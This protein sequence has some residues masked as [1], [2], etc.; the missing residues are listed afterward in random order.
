[1]SFEDRHNEKITQ[2]LTDKSIAYKFA[3]QCANSLIGTCGMP[4]YIESGTEFDR[5]VAR[6]QYR[7]KSSQHV[8]KVVEA[9]KRYGLLSHFVT[10]KE[11][12]VYITI[13]PTKSVLVN[14]TENYFEQLEARI[15]NLEQ[16]LKLYDSINNKANENNKQEQQAHNERTA[17]IDFI[18][19][20]PQQCENKESAAEKRTTSPES[21]DLSINDH[22][23]LVFDV[24][25][26]EI[27]EIENKDIP[28]TVVKQNIEDENVKHLI[29]PV[30]IK[31]VNETCENNNNADKISND[32]KS[33]EDSLSKSAKRRMKKKLRDRMTYTTEAYFAISK[34]FNSRE[35][36]FGNPNLFKWDRQPL[37]DSFSL[38]TDRDNFVC[39]VKKY[40][41]QFIRIFDDK[42]SV[43]SKIV[44]KPIDSNHMLKLPTNELKIGY[45]YDVAFGHA[46]L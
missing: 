17:Q 14:R 41:A 23:E 40:P 21:E 24:V 33:E 31:D 43:N 20:S 36:A 12:R 34:W 15:E 27:T 6:I 4:L 10:Y 45:L 37:E 3:W 7:L 8:S 35:C 32:N 2:S 5:C 25:K 44:Y 9:Y 39:A 13:A 22:R 16:K 26:T 38:E 1:M 42:A 28:S 18:H 30:N 11:S 46:P 19:V 29:K